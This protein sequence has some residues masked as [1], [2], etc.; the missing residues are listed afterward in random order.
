MA[1]GELI[2][3]GRVSGVLFLLLGIESL[4]F[5]DGIGDAVDA[6]FLDLFE[7]FLFLFLLLQEQGGE[8]LLDFE[9]LLAF[10]FSGIETLVQGVDVELQE[11]VVIILFGG[12]LPV[13][14][15]LSE[16][17]ALGYLFFV[18]VFVSGGRRGCFS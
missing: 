17:N 5:F 6:L 7:V 18:E 9:A 14:E 2:E 4:L 13:E 12:D 3:H 15:F 16:R 8:L 1:S 10:Q 11:L